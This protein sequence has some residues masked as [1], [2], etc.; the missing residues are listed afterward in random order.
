MVTT[1]P[2][3]PPRA[4]VTAQ[5]AVEKELRSR[6]EVKEG[7][8]RQERVAANAQLLAMQQA[9]AAEMEGQRVRARLLL[10]CL[11]ACVYA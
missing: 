9:H 3:I 11:P 2:S 1:F 8:E 10:A 4:Q 5:L 6:A 7:E